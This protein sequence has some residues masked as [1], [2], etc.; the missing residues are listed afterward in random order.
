[1]LGVEDL[2][3]ILCSRNNVGCLLTRSGPRP[4]K[5]GSELL[6]HLRKAFTNALQDW[7][8]IVENA[9]TVELTRPVP[10]LSPPTLTAPCPFCSKHFPIDNRGWYN[11]TRM[12]DQQCN[13]SRGGWYKTSGWKGTECW[14]QSLSVSPAQQRERVVFV[15]GFDPTAYS[16]NPHPVTHLPPKLIQLSCPEYYPESWW[17]L[18]V[19]LRY[20]PTLPVIEQSQGKGLD[21]SLLR[22]L[23]A[24]PS[25]ARAN[26]LTQDTQERKLEDALIF[27]RPFFKIYLQKAGV[28]AEDTF[29]FSKILK[30]YSGLNF[31]GQFKNESTYTL[32]AKAAVDFIS[33][34][35]RYL[36]H[37]SCS[38]LFQISMPEDLNQSF[39]RLENAI[40]E[41]SEELS[42][43]VLAPFCHDIFVRLILTKHPLISR[44]LTLLEVVL[45]IRTMRHDDK[46]L[47]DASVFT[48]SLAMYCRIFSATTLLAMI[49]GG[50]DKAY[51]LPT[52][53]VG[54]V[55][56]GK[57]PIGDE[58]E[59]EEEQEWGWEQEI[60]QG[61]QDDEDDGSNDS[62]D[63]DDSDSNN[64]KGGDGSDDDDN[65]GGDGSDDDD[66]DDSGD[67]D[68]KG[69]SSD[70]DDNSGSD[71]NDGSGSDDNDG[72]G[73]D[74]NDGSGSDDNDGSGSDDNNY[75]S[76]DD[77]S[78][79]D[80]ND[81]DSHNGSRSHS[82]NSDDNDQDSDY[83]DL[84]SADSDKDSDDGDKDSIYDD[85][86]NNSPHQKSRSKSSSDSHSDSRVPIVRRAKVNIEAEDAGDLG[87]ILD[88]GI[89]RAL[90]KHDDASKTPY[91]ILVMH[92][93]KASIYS[94]SVSGAKAF[95]PFPSNLGFSYMPTATTSRDFM[96]SQ[97]PEHY[98]FQIGE[99][100]KA[101]DDVVPPSLS[102][103]F[104]KNFRIGD[105]SDDPRCADSLFRQPKNAAYVEPFV[106]RLKKKLM[107]AGDEE[108]TLMGKNKGFS[109]DKVWAWIDALEAFQK[110]LVKALFPTIGIPPRAFQAASLVYD[111]KARLI[112]CLKI[113][114][115]YVILCNPIAKQNS[116]RQYECFWA[117]H[118][119]VAWFLLFFL[120]V[121]RPTLIFLLEHSPIHNCNPV[122]DL[123]NF[124]FAS[125]VKERLE[126]VNGSFCWKGPDIDECLKDTSLGLSCNDLRQVNTGI[127]RHW[128]PAL[129]QAYAN[130]NNPEGMSAMDRQ[131]QHSARVARLFYGR[132]LYLIGTNFNE[133]EFN[134]QIHVSFAMQRLEQII[135]N[136]GHV[137]FPT[138]I[139]VVNAL[140]RN[141]TGAM[142]AARIF[143]AEKPGYGM[144]SVR[145]VELVRQQS[146]QLLRVQPFLRGPGASIPRGNW[147]PEWT[148]FGDEGLVRVTAALARN[149]HLEAAR[150]GPMRGGYSTKFVASAAYLMSCAVD[151]W[152]TGAFA[153]V[154]W[155]GDPRRESTISQFEAAIMAFKQKNMEKWV[156]FRTTVDRY[157]LND[158][159]NQDLPAFNEQPIFN[160]GLFTMENAQQEN[161]ETA[162]NIS[163]PVVDLEVI[164]AR[165]VIAELEKK[166]ARI[167]EEARIREE[168]RT[169]VQ[170]RGENEEQAR[171]KKAKKE[172]KRAKEEGRKEKG[173]GRRE[174]GERKK[175]K[176]KERED[177]GAANEGAIAKESNKEN[178]KSRKRKSSGREDDAETSSK[179][180][181][182]EKE[183]SK[184]DEGKAKAK[185]KEKGSTKDHGKPRKRKSSGQEDEA[186]A[187]TSKRMRTEKKES[188]SK[189]RAVGREKHRLMDKNSK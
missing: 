13:A 57:D 58:Q 102:T 95:Q 142:S 169:E 25:K 124:I 143:V 167:E 157:A 79:S 24:T 117:L 26:K 166:E 156:E 80:D 150:A 133:V 123:Q 97:F 98:K 158:P 22:E 77:N 85:I 113:I 7:D 173:E 69:S 185:A 159:T 88:E 66:K 39:Q 180:R 83:D 121:L 31:R 94:R 160:V 47:V 187:T 154:N 119:D 151:E 50:W 130:L 78:G 72:S 181:R 21:P 35:L 27:C 111:S 153:H 122:K 179:R 164:H 145:D 42:I 40:Y 137:V 134:A 46:G 75:G 141:G 131:G 148:T 61:E 53:E 103:F 81:R 140:A 60:A 28:G 175:E 114:D 41:G 104:R 112:R 115:S 2:S 89:K 70:D 3:E 86:N 33:F 152:K 14:S 186:E 56:G 118:S 170:V 146:Q 74:D 11:H 129:S 37:P 90:S 20:R 82:D 178:Q 51:H 64:G 125:V 92:W 63:S 144:A 93:A 6:D 184:K 99:L 10:Y 138:T 116:L 96:L 16:S 188:G 19:D 162:G 110:I 4:H 100:R 149:Y 32:Y 105:F 106:E 65:C 73:S 109:L 165:E 76:D 23:I 29:L 182:S 59:Q 136:G 174:K 126:N 43:V 87:R 18:L 8:G 147:V 5:I 155:E 163:Q 48:K 128:Y 71:D 108:P 135:E 34:T 172:K 132:D 177:K 38:D 127:I 17:R 54:S 101:F 91:R 120:G 168:A 55:E 1:M 67:D 30:K 161:E 36:I 183:K 107:I 176:E 9:S 68:D 12:G 139:N 52:D 44:E 171:R 15:K 45:M 189:K 62:D 84:D 49:N